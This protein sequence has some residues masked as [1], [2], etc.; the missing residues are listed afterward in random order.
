[1]SKVREAFQKCMLG[2]KGKGKKGQDKACS[3]FA[4]LPP[5]IQ[6]L[7]ASKVTSARNRAALARTGR[8]G[9]KA[10]RA[11][12]PAWLAER[13]EA[14]SKLGNTVH[15]PMATA[16]FQA[17]VIGPHVKLRWRQNA[18]GGRFFNKFVRL[19]T[20]PKSQG[21]TN[22]E[23]MMRN[24]AG[25]KVFMR[26][27][28]PDALYVSPSGAK[29]EERAVA[30]VKSKN[31]YHVRAVDSSRPP[32]RTFMALLKKAMV[33]AIGL[34]LAQTGKSFLHLTLRY[35]RWRATTVEHL[36]VF[37]GGVVQT[38]VIPKP[39]PRKTIRYYIPE[40]P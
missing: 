11:T 36:T 34:E 21:G 38:R 32:T 19:G 39:P 10:V 17:F 15:R 31:E 1:M 29:M 18:G 4:G 20:A 35:S 24:I 6:A 28:V 37:P 2:F 22:H 30:I 40:N 5:N 14:V 23:R 27:A 12:Q 13:V 16:I 25:P 33:S 7:V 9:A 26:F 3:A 8:N